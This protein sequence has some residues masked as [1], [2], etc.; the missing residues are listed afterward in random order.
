M[1]AWTGY[2]ESDDQAYAEA[3]AGWIAHFPFLGTGHHALRH[4]L[5]LP[6]ALVF[7]LFGPSEVALELP[8]LAYLAGILL[9]TYRCTRAVAGDLAAVLALIVVGTIP[10]LVLNASI[11]TTDIPE[12]FFVLSSVWAFFFGC[13]DR[14]IWLFPLA[15]ALAGLGFITRETSAAVLVLYGILFLMNYGGSR[16][17]Y[18]WMGLGFAAVAG[19]D[20]AALWVASGDPLYRF[21]V[22]LRGVAADSPLAQEKFRSREAPGVDRFGTIAVPWPWKPLTVVFLNQQFGLLAWFAVPAAVATTMT[23]TATA[24]RPAARLLAAAALIWFLVLFYGLANYLNTVARYADFAAVCVAVP[25]SILLARHWHRFAA[26]AC[27]AAVVGINIGLILASDTRPLFAEKM[28][29]A[30][31]AQS[32]EPIATDPGTF[33]GAALLLDWRGLSDRVV[34]AAPAPGGLYFFANRPRRGIPE[35]WTVREPKVEWRTIASVEKPGKPLARV[36]RLLNVRRFVPRG[37]ADKLDPP[38]SHATLYRVP[39]G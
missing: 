10:A 13:R 31:A 39:A 38:L 17:A 6:M 37:I 2:T 20:F 29:V 33:Q 18:V 21:H 27:L 15:G 11:A 7:R 9:V 25:L 16:L 3:A 24:D 28:L 23:R 4:A 34:A 8:M 5:V 35:H 22:S 12:T 36:A 32:A 1:G 14:K 26:K 30:L 19:L